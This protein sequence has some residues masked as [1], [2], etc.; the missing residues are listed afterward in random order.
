[1]KNKKNE[2]KTEEKWFYDFMF[3]KRI[4]LKNFLKKHD[5]IILQKLGIKIK[6]MRCTESDV[7]MIK[8]QLDEYYDIRWLQFITRTPYEE[9][10]LIELESN[11]EIFS[12]KAAAPKSIAEAGVT[13][14]EF[15][16]VYENIEVLKQAIKIYVKYGTERPKIKQG[17]DILN[18]YKHLIINRIKQAGAVL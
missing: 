5:F 16:Y 14:D 6:K 15:E 12:K 4:N 2:I 7:G 8:V 17:R 9:K 18:I 3:K 11:R 10:R 13:R 1:M